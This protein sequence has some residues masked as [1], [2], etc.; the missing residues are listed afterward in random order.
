MIFQEKIGRTFEFCTPAL[1]DDHTVVTRGSEQ[2]QE[3]NL[4]KVLNLI[5]K[6]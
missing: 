2:G 3:E 1:L 5:Q 4:L 6:S